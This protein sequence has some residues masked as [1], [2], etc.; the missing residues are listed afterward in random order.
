MLTPSRSWPC[1]RHPARGQRG[2]TLIEVLVSILIASFGLLALAGLQTTMNSAVLESYQRAQALTLLQNMAQRIEVNQ[3]NANS[4][5]SGS[6]FG[7][8]DTQPTACNSTTLPGATRAQMDQCEWSQLLKGASETAGTA[9]V[10]AMIGGR[11]CVE[12]VQAPNAASGVCQPGIYRVTVAWQGL[13]A[14]V[15][16][17]QAC[18]LNQYTNETLRKAISTQVLVA[19]PNC[20]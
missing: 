14:T 15:A 20:S 13:N 6:A 18:G 16:P 4:Y 1:V 11:G 7:T 19:L 5:V 12:V 9:N 8:A 2:G 10:G 17:A 3:A